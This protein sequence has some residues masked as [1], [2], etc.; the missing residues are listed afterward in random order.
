MRD[1]ELFVYRL[2]LIMG[3][4]CIIAD[5]KVRRFPNYASA[6]VVTSSY[7]QRGYIDADREG[8]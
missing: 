8:D 2:R 4:W 6:D 1:P 5:G 3:A 7:R